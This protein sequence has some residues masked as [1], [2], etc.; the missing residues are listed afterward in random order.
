MNTAEHK[1]EAAVSPLV[2][3]S[4]PQFSPFFS[5]FYEHTC[6]VKEALKQSM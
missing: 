2:I 1:L 4:N 3:Y 5:K 6:E